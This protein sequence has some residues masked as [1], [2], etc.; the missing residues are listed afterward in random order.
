MMRMLQDVKF[1]QFKMMSNRIQNCKLKHLTEILSNA[2]EQTRKKENQKMVWQSKYF[3]IM[4]IEQ[5]KTDV[6]VGHQQTT[7]ARF[8][9]L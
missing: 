9:K 1:K 2:V 4:N 3:Y 5:W 6:K 8:N 7:K